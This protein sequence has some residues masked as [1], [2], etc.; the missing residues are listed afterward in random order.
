MLTDN[1]RTSIIAP[2]IDGLLAVKHADGY[3]YKSEELV[4]N[5]FDKYCYDRNLDTPVI[6]RAFLDEWMVR[7]EHEGEFNRGKRISCVRQLL[8]FM[9]ACG[10]KEYIPHD[11]CHFKKALPHI[12]AQEELVDF[13]KQVDSYIPRRRSARRLAEES[14]L[15]FRWYLCLG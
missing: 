4:L 10:L 14:R 12:F 8:L 3:D 9:A 13:F 1:T 2:Y 6:T 5:R 7:A 11:F 15:L